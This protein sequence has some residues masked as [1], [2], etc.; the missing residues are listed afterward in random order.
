MLNEI[1]RL[2][3]DYH[4]WL[5]EKV[6]LRQVDEWVEITT[7]YLDRYN[8]WLQLYVKQTDRGYLISDDGY[9]IQELEQSGCSLDTPNRQTLL[10]TTLNGFGVKIREDV[11]EVDA[12]E[13]NFAQKK[14]NLLQAMIAV[15][16]LFYTAKPVVESL[17]YEDVVKWLEYHEIRYTARIRFAGR[18]GYDHSFDFL[19]PRSPIAP[20]RIMKAINKPNRETAQSMVFSWLD[21]K[22]DR[23]PNS[24][25]YAILND[26][27]ALIRGAVVDALH[28]YDIQAMSWSTKEEYLPELVN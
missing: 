14:H 11:L 15:N 17:F 6:Q 7:P 18:S 8:D 9:T 27:E 28:N 21:T 5:R 19:I 2:L 24:R 10:R 25:A 16:D 3:E 22:S 26:S 23:P 4:S 13:E 1:R 20:E 12:S